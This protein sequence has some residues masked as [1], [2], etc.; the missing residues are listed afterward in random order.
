MTRKPTA[1]AKRPAHR[2][3]APLPIAGYLGALIGYAA[4]GAHH[5][6]FWLDY[7]ISMNALG[8]AGAVLAALPGVRD[9]RHVIPTRG[10]ARHTATTHAALNSFALALYVIALALYASSWND[11]T[12]S[13]AAG[14]TLTALGTAATATAVALGRSLARDHRTPPRGVGATPITTWHATE[15]DSPHRRR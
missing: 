2:M 15:A 9:L 13:A 12:R 10:P 7:A 6:S 5:S 1:I 4:Y 14:I 11:P 3:L 8:V